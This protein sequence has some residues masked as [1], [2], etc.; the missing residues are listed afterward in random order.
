MA[1]R[2]WLGLK[3]E[4]SRRLEALRKVNQK[5][6]QPVLRNLHLELVISSFSMILLKYCCLGTVYRGSV[7]M[8]HLRQRISRAKMNVDFR[9]PIKL[10]VFWLVEV[11]S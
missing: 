7:T 2:P 9:K 8:Q 1:V 6:S 3:H 10:F 5:G 11:Y 4:D